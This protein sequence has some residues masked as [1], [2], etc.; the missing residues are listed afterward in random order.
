MYYHLLF[1]L[2]LI[3]A[4]IFIWAYYQK[5]HQAVFYTKVIASFF[6]VFASIFIL[7]KMNTKPDA[8]L[9]VIG[10]ICGFFGDVF[11]DLKHVIPK[12]HKVA[13]VLGVWAFMCGHLFYIAY[14]LLYVIRDFSSTVVLLE[15]VV[16][17]LGFAKIMWLMKKC[18]PP[19]ILIGLGVVYLLILDLSFGLALSV[20]N[21]CGILMVLGTFFFMISDHMLI[22]DYFGKK[23]YPSFHGILLVLYYAAQWCIVYSILGV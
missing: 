6:F 18:N 22:Y 4:G 17:V 15:L 3:W 10:L 16:G 8:I 12:V 9:V 13:F 1:I 21:Q 7:L 23:K 20:M 2:G 19:T 14:N 5:K 11:L